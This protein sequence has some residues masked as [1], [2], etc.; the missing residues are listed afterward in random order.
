MELNPLL[1]LSAAIC[2]GAMIPLIA[3]VYA[4]YGKGLVTWIHLYMYPCFAAAGVCGV[5][6]GHQHTIKSLLVSA[7]I[8]LP[9]FPV[10]LALLYRRAVAPVREVSEQLVQRAAE[11]SAA[12]Q[13][14]AATAAEQ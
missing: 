4:L 1:L 10:A 9:L 2:A 12:A 6:I 3:V 8:V 7:A 5:Y 13:Q 14:S 11:V